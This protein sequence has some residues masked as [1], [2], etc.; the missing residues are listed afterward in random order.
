[1]SVGEVFRQRRQEIDPYKLGRGD[2]AGHGGGYATGHGGGGSASARVI[3]GFGFWIFLLSDVIL[4]S[5]FFAAF[6]V[7]RNATDG[8]PT[9]RDI[10]ELWRVA[11]ETAFLL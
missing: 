3:T 6:A 8:G 9:G 10:L 5:C 11:A 2:A 7:L 4:F 1:M